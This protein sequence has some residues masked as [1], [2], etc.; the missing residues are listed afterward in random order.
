M[1]VYWLGMT[2]AILL[3]I[4]YGACIL[5]GYDPDNLNYLWF[6][7]NDVIVLHYFHT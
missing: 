6:L 3:I 1:K 7:F 4:T 5:A 2:L